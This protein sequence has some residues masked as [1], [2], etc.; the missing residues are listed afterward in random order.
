MFF[1]DVYYLR[2]FKNAGKNNSVQKPN[3]FSEA[4]QMIFY[5]VL[6][7]FAKCCEVEG[8]GGCSKFEQCPY[9]DRLKRKAS[10]TMHFRNHV[11]EHDTVDVTEHVIKHVTK[12]VRDQ[13][14]YRDGV[15]M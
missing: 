5:S 7:H 10:L 1:L 14:G 2:L 4:N 13:S 9:L 11:T 8:V 6:L 3:T 12:H 15:T